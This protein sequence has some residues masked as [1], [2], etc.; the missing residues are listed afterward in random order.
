M[1]KISCQLT[2][3]HEVAEGRLGFIL[4]DDAQVMQASWKQRRSASVTP[5]AKVEH[6]EM[7]LCVTA[8]MC[9]QP[10]SSGQLIFDERDLGIT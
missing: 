9:P 10:H 1:N 3:L 5:R 8:K 6:R 2:G 4:D 7:L